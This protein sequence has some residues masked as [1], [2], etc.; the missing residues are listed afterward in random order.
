LLL[1]EAQG[2]THTKKNLFALGVCVCLCACACVCVCVCVCVRVCVCVC[3]CVCA[4][5]YRNKRCRKRWQDTTNPSKF[6]NA[7]SGAVCER[8]RALSLHACMYA[9][10]RLSH[11][12]THTHTFSPLLSPLPPPPCSLSLSSPPSLRAIAGGC[13][14]RAPLAWRHY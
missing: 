8:A 5:V 3:V 1:K 10:V 6:G 13:N 4:C 14:K 2:G 12:D 11:T 7:M 9:S